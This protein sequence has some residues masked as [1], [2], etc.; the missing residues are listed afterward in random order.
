MTPEEV[1]H[2]PNDGALLLDGGDCPFS[3]ALSERVKMEVD[4]KMRSEVKGEVDAV[5]QEDSTHAAAAAA[6]VSSRIAS[7]RS[8]PSEVDMHTTHWAMSD[9]LPRSAMIC[10]EGR[11]LVEGG[12]RPAKVRRLSGEGG[13]VEKDSRMNSMTAPQ[14][15]GEH[16][17]LLILRGAGR[18][19]TIG[20]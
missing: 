4:V 5:S 13:A 11:D 14:M 15:H 12:A 16:L 7:L 19:G 6:D 1:P 3:V 10:S 20:C 2:S 18:R 17:S 8:S 9:D